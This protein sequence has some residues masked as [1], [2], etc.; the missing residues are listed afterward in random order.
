MRKF[1]KDTLQL[2]AVMAVA[3][4]VGIVAEKLLAAS[5]TY[6]YLAVHGKVDQAQLSDEVGFVTLK[7]LISMLAF[8]VSYLLAALFAWKWS[9]SPFQKPDV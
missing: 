4:A 8:F 9:K 1:V 6:G 5:F 3:T 7:L 2:V